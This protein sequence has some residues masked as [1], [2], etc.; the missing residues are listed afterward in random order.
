[1]SFHHKPANTST[2]RQPMYR[3]AVIAYALQHSHKHQFVQLPET[4]CY[5]EPRS[6]LYCRSQHN[7]G[8]WN[9]QPFYAFGVGAASYLFE[10]RFSRPRTMK[11]YQQWVSEFASNS[12]GGTEPAPGY[13]SMEPEAS[14]EQLLDYVMLRLRLADGIPMDA[15]Q[16][17]FGR[18]AADVVQTTLLGKL[19]YADKYA[20]EIILQGQRHIRLTDPEGFLMSNDCIATLFAKLDDINCDISGADQVS[21]VP[22]SM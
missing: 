10:R 9:N 6:P 18:L 5:V 13:D 22:A 19:A 11:A 7:L 1:M 15:L 16:R 21:K 20:C 3:Q 12:K 8:Y 4:L 17:K 2:S 14:E